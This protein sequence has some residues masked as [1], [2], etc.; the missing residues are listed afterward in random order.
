M[1][2]TVR[3]EGRK[4]IIEIDMDK[5]DGH[6]AKGNLLIASTNGFKVIESEF[7]KENETLTLNLNLVKFMKK[8]SANVIKI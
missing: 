3:K 2:L 7:A 4:M 1:N 8:E 5:N 6:S